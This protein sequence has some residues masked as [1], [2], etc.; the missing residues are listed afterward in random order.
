MSILWLGAALGL[1][2]GILFTLSGLMLAG[3]PLNA[4]HDGKSMILEGVRASGGGWTPAL[5]SALASA[6]TAASVLSGAAVL[7]AAGRVFRGR[8]AEPDDRG[9]APSR[10]SLAAMAAIAAALLVASALAALPELAA[11]IA[12]GAHTFVR[13]ADYAR[14]VLDEMPFAAAPPAARDEWGLDLQDFL[15]P[16]TAVALAA[17]VMGRRELPW[18]LRRA[19]G[20]VLGGAAKLHRLHT[21]HIGDSIAWMI[22]GVCVMG[23]WTAI[24]GR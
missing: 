24:L 7:L 15:A 13:T 19:I 5:A 11:G 21:G 18:P 4:A 16:A 9:A 3:L 2:T 12:R 1:L 17:I 23:A 14:T 8:G 20:L 22:A 6:L 10:A